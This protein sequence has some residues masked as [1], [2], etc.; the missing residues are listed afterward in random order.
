MNKIIYHIY[1]TQVSLNILCFSLFSFLVSL[2][3]L[4][5][6]S[7]SSSDLKLSAYLQDDSWAAA[8]K[9]EFEQEY[10]KQ[11]EVQLKKDYKAG[12]QVFP[13]KHLIFNAFNKT[14]IDK[15]NTRL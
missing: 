13:P 12:V 5:H 15:V 7:A 3:V 8:L 1:I 11:L 9:P 6:I 10:F 14:P 4:F 2:I